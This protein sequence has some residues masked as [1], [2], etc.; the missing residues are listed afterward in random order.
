[1]CTVNTHILKLV[2]DTHLKWSQDLITP[3]GRVIVRASDIFISE[4]AH[5]Y[6]QYY[7]RNSTKLWQK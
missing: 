6:R 7:Y 3:Q 5:L 2:K 1:M 4:L